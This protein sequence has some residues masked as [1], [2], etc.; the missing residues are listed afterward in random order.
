MRRFE[1][2]GE[3]K[4]WQIELTGT[5]A[6][7][8]WGKI[9]GSGKN[10]QHKTFAS[11][12][13][14]KTEIAKLV[15]KKT[16][17]GFVEI[18]ATATPSPTPPPSPTPSPS[19]VH[20][21]GAKIVWRSEFD[22]RVDAP[23]GFALAGD[24]KKCLA[25]IRAYFDA[26][27]DDTPHKTK[28]EKALKSAKA[29]GRALAQRILTSYAI[30][31]APPSLDA[32][33]DAALIIEG[34]PLGAVA[35]FIHARGGVEAL[36][37]TLIATFEVKVDGDDEDGY[38]FEVG[39]VDYI[40][41]A[42]SLLARIIRRCM[43]DADDATRARVVALLASAKAST[44]DFNRHVLFAC[45]TNEAAWT[46]EVVT[47]FVGKGAGNH[48]TPRMLFEFVRDPALVTRLAK[49]APGSVPAFDLVRDL[50]LDA[51]DAVI[52]HHDKE[53]NYEWAAEALSMIES[54]AAAKQMAQ[55]LGK[56]RTTQIAKEYFERRPDL[57][58]PV[59]E[60]IVKGD[61]KLAPFA[62]PV[63]E[64]ILRAHPELGTGPQK[65][66]A[67]VASASS[68]PRS[69]A[70]PPQ[71]KKAVTLPEWSN[72][73]PQVLLANGTALPESAIQ[74]LLL[75][76]HESPLGA[77][78]PA[79][80]E[81]K[82]S[83]D[84]KSLAGFAWALF[85][86]W[87]AASGSSKEGWAF[88]AVGHLGGDD[89]ARRLAPLVR[90]WP[91]ESQH[92]R[93]VVG[94]DV[95]GAIGTDVALMH[96]HGVALKIKFK[97]LQEKAKLKMDALAK[98]RGLTADELA[99]RLVPDL[100]L[101]HETGSL[102]LDF[103][104]RQFTVAFDEEL[105][106]YV[107]DTSHVK[108]PDLPKP[109]QSDDA[110]K[111]KEAV[112]R[113][114]SLKKDAKAVASTQITRLELGM[115][116][117]RRWSANE[118]RTFIAE[119]PLV[120]HLARRL[121]WGVYEKDKLTKTTFRVA[122]DRSLVSADDVEVKLAKDARVGLLHRLDVDEKTLAAWGDHL[123]RYELL[124]PFDQLGRALY[125]IEAKE[126]TSA[127]LNRMKDVTVKT[128]KVLGLEV[129]GWR[130]GAAQDA[131]WVWDMNKTI[132]DFELTLPLG[133][134]LCMGWHEGT[135]SDQK[136]GGVTIEKRGARG[137][138]ANFGMLSPVAFS[139]LVRELE[140]MRDA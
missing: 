91:G 23:N 84:P 93:A 5:E 17:E 44:T 127:T 51:T 89:E 58:V 26:V 9:G 111:S 14:A 131:G 61:A 135:P 98:A 128:G 121:V 72:N 101:D 117:Q 66:V 39:P 74:N 76:L 105:K 7:I 73:L 42:S 77:P 36:A 134:G 113:Y 46:E 104:P 69:L 13:V 49:K 138:K 116:A 114:K 54:P 139:E 99:D 94:L 16:T 115:C 12:S 56:K 63:L 103:G 71:L 137:S 68:V 124:Q 3:K 37:K 79:L 132:G 8:E 85:E 4:F 30:G 33:G 60:P 119:H 109:K 83:C 133:G 18:G 59:L 88:A 65:V 81:V 75:V 48:R 92:A 55:S 90:A 29:D 25:E 118:F 87:L 126:K 125:A 20:S 57:A 1:I 67:K 19:P 130:K 45:A 129:R 32:M 21:A 43:S 106:P 95:L 70:T 11:E 100:G 82:A 52:A 22:D 50:G 6:L 24:E 28:I 2:E 120:V 123:G 122:E 78:H 31:K 53:P 80:A 34:A 140:M 35:G 136:L 38:F 41:H 10:R 27:E 40:N 108:L 96:L 97:G 64:A 86:S 112:E 47:A 62:R 110:E 102:S 107:L 15:A